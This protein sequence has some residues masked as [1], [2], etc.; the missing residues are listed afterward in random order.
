MLSPAPERRYGHAPILVP[1]SGSPHFSRKLS[2]TS[3]LHHKAVK[4]KFESGHK[5][6][7]N[8]RSAP[9]QGSH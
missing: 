3:L 7:L 6:K 2:A 1:A 8:Q 5:T 9:P 4:Y